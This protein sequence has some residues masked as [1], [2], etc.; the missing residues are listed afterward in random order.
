MHDS[1]LITYFITSLLKK[2]SI[3]KD[4]KLSLCSPITFSPTSVFINKIPIF[5]NSIFVPI[6]PNSRT[7]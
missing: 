5:A 7:A 3:K 2:H 4:K 6:F 1:V